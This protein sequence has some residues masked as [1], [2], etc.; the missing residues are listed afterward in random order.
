MRLPLTALFLESVMT[1]LYTRKL[2]LC[3]IVLKY[4]SHF[5]QKMFLKT[6]SRLGSFRSFS[7]DITCGSLAFSKDLSS[8]N[9]ARNFVREDGIFSK[10]VPRETW[11]KFMLNIKTFYVASYNHFY[12]KMFLKTTSRL[13]PNVSLPVTTAAQ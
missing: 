9:H 10:D 5:Y 13:G 7:L 1:F 3:L 11:I 2:F 8:I 4:T 12:Q 6:T